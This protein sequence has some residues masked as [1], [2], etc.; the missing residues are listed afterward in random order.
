[1]AN[2]K[3]SIDRQTLA[4]IFKDPQ[5]VRAMESLFQVA[6]SMDNSGGTVTITGGTIDNTAIGATT[7][8]P[9]DFTILHAGQLFV[10]DTGT[11][12]NLH[13]EYAETAGAANT[14]NSANSATTAV[15]LLGVNDVAHGG[16]GLSSTPANGQIDIGNGA[17]FTRATLTA[18]ANITITNGP[19]GIT[20]S[21]T[22]GGSAAL[23]RNYISGFGLT[24]DTTTPATVL[25]VA[26][27]QASDSTNTATISGTAFRKS[28]GGSWVAG[29]GANGMGVGLTVSAN[30]WYHVFAIVASGSYDV[31]FDTSLTAA[32]KPAGST[33][34]RYIGSIKTDGSAQIIGFTQVGQY[35]YWASQIIDIGLPTTTSN[36]LAVI[37]TPPG[38]NCVANITATVRAAN[39]TVWSPLAGVPTAVILRNYSTSGT[40]AA[41]LSGFMTNLASQLYYVN[42]VTG[43]DMFI[44]TTGYINPL[45]AMN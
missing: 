13:A 30:T 19:G 29:T 28:I 16:T 37:S 18:G 41:A 4:A 22:G 27:G 26:A 12:A 44:S 5:A 24:N 2:T 36:T 3:I 34:V 11:V 15:S 6:S 33:A 39:A 31:Y 17:G 9:G 20:I 32:N 14:A 7:P 25:A 35:F 43:G 38:I 8:A 45:V 1:V 42:D 23:P 10:D 40:V 21:S